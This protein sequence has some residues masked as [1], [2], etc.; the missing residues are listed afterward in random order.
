MLHRSHA[1]RLVGLGAVALLGSVMAALPANAA[2]AETRITLTVRGCEGCVIQAFGGTL[3]A[4]GSPW[5][6]EKTPVRKGRVTLTVP[7]KQTKGMLFEINTADGSA[8]GIDAV[9]DIVMSYEGIPAG[10]RVTPAQAKRATAA[11]ACWAGTKDSAATLNVR[12]TRFTATGTMDE[13][14][15]TLRAWTSPSQA[16]RGEFQKTGN[17]GQAADQNP[18]YCAKP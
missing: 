12:V 8:A 14:V 6:S 1:S 11:V 13:P 4:D 16:G 10:S 3:R 15:T 18:G 17:G 7:T 5:Q 9:P 2:G